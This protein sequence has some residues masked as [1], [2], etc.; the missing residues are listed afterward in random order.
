MFVDQ[1]RVEQIGKEAEKDTGATSS[2][3]SDTASDAGAS[4]KL[5]NGS[6]EDGES[7]NPGPV[8]KKVCVYKIDYY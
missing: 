1:L 4:D 2:N 5:E 8:I 6:T 3:A 7:A